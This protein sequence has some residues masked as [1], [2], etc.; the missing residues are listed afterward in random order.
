MEI[1]AVGLETLALETKE[2]IKMLEMPVAV[3][4]TGV[5]QVIM[6]VAVQALAILVR[7]LMVRMMKNYLK[8]EILSET[9]G[10]LFN[11]KF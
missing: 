5:G 6:G 10:I 3:I 11:Q 7:A 1:V 8:L 4:I 9:G 2:M